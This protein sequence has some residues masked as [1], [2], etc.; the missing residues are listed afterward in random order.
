MR[1]LPFDSSVREQVCTLAASVG[2]ERSLTQAAGGNISWKENET[3][4]VKASGMCLAD[5]LRSDIFVALEFEGAL[6]QINEKQYDFSVG[7]S[8]GTLRPSIET[9]FH[10][11]LPQKIILHLHPVDVIAR[12]IQV[13]GEIGIAQALTG[14]N[15]AWLDYCKPGEM[16]AREIERVSDE[17]D[18]TPDV[19]ILANHGI[20]VCAETVPDVEDLLHFVMGRLT[21]CPRKPE[22]MPDPAWLETWIQLGYRRPQHEV[23]DSLALDEISHSIAKKSW[24]L[25]PDHAV[26]L[27]AA[28]YFFE[29]AAKPDLALSAEELPVVIIVS[30][31]GVL[32]S[33][34]A[35]SA[36]EAML[37]CYAD[38][39]LRL[40]DPD[41][42]TAL[43]SEQVSELIS[44]DA[45]EYRRRMSG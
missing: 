12:S 40:D 20:V 43:D 34:R 8:E 3:I 1:E 17:R 21:L 4:F 27:G 29:Y 2:A 32:L 7:V 13:G 31:A 33:N 39:L 14:L 22:K 10:I 5:A 26:F 37:T 28:G 36:C 18:V 19:W 23:V 25:Y 9:A 11:V 30:G 6:R 42:V 35:S 24:V 44:W 45:E 16:L 41:A 38:V 15:W